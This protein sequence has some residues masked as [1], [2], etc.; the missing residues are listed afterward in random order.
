MLALAL[1]NMKDPE[2]Q[3]AL[4]GLLDDDLVAGQAIVS[5][6]Q[7]EVSKSLSINRAILTHPESLDTQRSKKGLS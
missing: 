7:A 1:G 2:A 4:I 3:D 5:L 6:R